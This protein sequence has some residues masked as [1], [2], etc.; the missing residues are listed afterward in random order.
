MANNSFAGSSGYQQN[1]IYNGSNFNSGKPL[2]LQNVNGLGLGAIEI[3]EVASVGTSNTSINNTGMGST[4]FL[5]NAKKPTGGFTSL[6]KN[7]AI[8][9]EQD[10]GFQFDMSDRYGI[11][12]S[13]DS[14][15]LGAVPQGATGNVVQNPLSIEQQNLD[16]RQKELD[17]N[18]KNSETS[19]MDDAGQALGL[20]ATGAN[21]WMGV[22]SFFDTRDLNKDKKT[23]L[24]QQID[25]NR[26]KSADRAQYKKDR[27]AAFGL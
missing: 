16:L 25:E 18:T 24:G 21:L 2:D 9:I 10:D 13:T 7:N 15:S 14:S 1:P 3:P 27:R 17:L 22:D 20:A 26:T 23:L 11:G 12:A 6:L 5:F 19:G 8:N 4:D